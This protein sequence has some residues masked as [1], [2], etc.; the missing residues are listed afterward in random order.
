[1]FQYFS[2]FLPKRK[3]EL[4]SQ[5][6]KHCPV[7][8]SVTL[9]E[10]GVTMEMCKYGVCILVLSPDHKILTVQTGFCA[11][12]VSCYVHLAAPLSEA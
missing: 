1:M 11:S 6:Q 8:I 7:F 10:S 2:H 3:C 9:K 5:F 12:P 4:A